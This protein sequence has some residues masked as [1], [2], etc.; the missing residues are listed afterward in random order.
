MHLL[1]PD[2]RQRVGRR[3][4]GLRRRRPGLPLGARLLEHKEI[5]V[6][7]QPERELEA[8]A[9]KRGDPGRAAGLCPGW[10]GESF[11]APVLL[12]GEVV[13]ILHPARFQSDDVARKLKRAEPIALLNRLVLVHPLVCAMVRE[14]K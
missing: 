3:P 14:R 11:R 10:E 5:I 6:H 1:A 12:R 2:V 13:E 9:V 4:L 7:A 8:H